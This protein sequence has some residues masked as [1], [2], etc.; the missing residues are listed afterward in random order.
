MGAGLIGRRHAGHVAREAELSAIVDPDPGARSVADHYNVPWFQDFDA[1]LRGNRPDGV[2]VATPTQHHVA[3]GLQ[4][5]GAGLPALIEKPVAADIAGA[6]QLVG[7]SEAA[8]IPILVGHHRRYNPLIGKAKAVIAAGSLGRL[9]AAHATCWFY[10]PKDYFDVAWRTQPGAGPVLTNLIHDIDLLRYLCGEVASVQA[11]VS[12]SVRGFDVE[13]TASV[14][15][16][17]RNGALGTL[18]VSDTVVAPWSWELT[19]AENPAYPRT[20]ESCYIIGGSAGSLSIPD[21][22][23]WHHPG[24]PSWW[25]PISRKS[26]IH[27]TGDPL[28]LQVRHF[29]NVALGREAPLVSGR[30]GLE[31]LKVVAAI[32]QAARNGTRT[33]IP[34]RPC[35]ISA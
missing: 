15:L 16:T 23:L 21:L 24:D 6:E 19:A 12:N 30:E 5:I 14:L 10:K 35:P 9:V 8:S 2:I 26:Q 33:A 1:M 29:S 28:A 4:C 31:T 34:A 18:T 7:A 17:F 25:D 20:G 27:E 3:N 11:Q 13:D 32:D 22:A